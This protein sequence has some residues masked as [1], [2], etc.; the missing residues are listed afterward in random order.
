[1]FSFT[2][3]AFD[4]NPRSHAGSDKC[5]R[6]SFAPPKIF[7]STLPRGERQI[8]G[9]DSVRYST[10]QSTLPRGER[11]RILT[12]LQGD[13]HFNPRSHAGSDL[14]REVSEVLFIV[15]QS[16]LP[17]GERHEKHWPHVENRQISIHAPT[18]GATPE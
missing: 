6:L 3:R 14:A 8:H 17:R 15:F 11:L 10:F 12:A 4:F 1:M 2:A 13:A 18:R 16:T 5:N 9:I 7:Q